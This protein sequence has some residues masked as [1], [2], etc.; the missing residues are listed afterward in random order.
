MYRVKGKVTGVLC[1]WDLAEQKTRDDDV[2][3][4]RA[5]VL[6]AVPT[7]STQNKTSAT[8]VSAETGG[9]D[10][11]ATKPR[12]RTGTG[13]FMAIDLLRKGPVPLHLYRHDLESFF[14]VLVYV[15]AVWDPI[16]EK[17]GHPP[18]WEHETLSVIGANR[19]EFLH[20]DEAYNELFV[21]AHP[22]LKALT[23]QGLKPDWVASL[24]AMFS[25]I[26]MHAANIA[27]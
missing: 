10:N 16:L 14:Y 17:L 3:S 5:Y 7:T 4:T 26:L 22:M 2:P 1:D 20:N 23:V 21:N 12:S 11:G 6:F 8:Q 9:P 15:C 24:S 13:P 18:G 25:V 19:A 27:G